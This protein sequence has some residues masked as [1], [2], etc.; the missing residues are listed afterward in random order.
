MRVSRTLILHCRHISTLQHMFHLTFELLLTAAYPTL[1]FI[2]SLNIW[3]T[4]IEAWYARTRSNRA[5]PRPRRWQTFL[6]EFGKTGWCLHF[7][8][9]VVRWPG[10]QTGARTK[11]QKCKKWTE[12]TRITKYKDDPHRDWRLAEPKN[13]ALTNVTWDSLYSTLPPL[14][15][16]HVCSNWPNAGIFVSPEIARLPGVALSHNANHAPPPHAHTHSTHFS[17]SLHGIP[18]LILDCDH[19]LRHNGVR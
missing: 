14:H 6:F 1:E 10:C 13:W 12:S 5:T 11:S 3:A 8:L 17:L 4:T 7:W 9:F 19:R 18:A 2:I 15:H 16:P